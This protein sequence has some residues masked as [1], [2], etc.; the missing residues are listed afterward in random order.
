MG[1]YKF[2]EFKEVD[3]DPVKSFHLK[4]ELNPDVWDKS[5]INSEVREKLLKIGEDFYASTDL[6]AEVIDIVL[7]G[8]LCNYNWDKKYSDYDL[9]IIINY[10]DINEDIKLV[11]KLCDLSKK[12]WNEQ[13][14]IKVKGYEV[15]VAIQDNGVLKMAIK[16]G[17]MGGVYSLLNDKW[18][19]KPEKVEFE[20]DEDLIREKS[21]SIMM[22]V[23][24]ILEKS[25]EKYPKI[26]EKIKKVWDKIKTLRERSLSEEGEFGIGN[27]VFKMLRR[28]NYLGKIMDLKR[29]SYDKQFEHFDD[30][31]VLKFLYEL[32]VISDRL[33]Q[34]S[35]EGSSS[36]LEYSLDEDEYIVTIEFGYSG[37]SDGGSDTW[38]VYYYDNMEQLKVE[39]QGH[40]TSEGEEFENNYTEYYDSF[41]Q[42]LDE[43]KN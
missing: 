14:D 18:V 25:D 2:F 1:L 43:L 22:E 35:T 32:D 39:K 37:Y 26:K 3:M 30:N 41:G 4:D 10:E 17:R 21:K 28:N 36:Y 20:P 23:D 11:E 27:L 15:E 29:N 6:E 38:K 40:G 9:H 24:D 31:S 33:N 7:C 5:D 12:L 8:S 42:I 34:Q 16:N 19:K 13:H